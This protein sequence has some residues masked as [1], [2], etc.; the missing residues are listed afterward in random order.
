[1]IEQQE[2][3]AKPYEDLIQQQNE[4]NFYLVF[5]IVCIG[6]SLVLTV[7]LCQ[8]LRTSRRI[9]RVIDAMTNFTLEL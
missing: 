3:Y 6:F 1:M 2:S 4:F 7:I 8:T 5:T 9:T